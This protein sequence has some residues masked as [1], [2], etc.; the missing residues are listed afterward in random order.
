MKVLFWENELTNL[1]NF[2]IIRIEKFTLLI[3]CATHGMTLSI[4]NHPR[5]KEI[6]SELGE[7]CKKDAVSAAFKLLVEFLANPS[8]TYLNLTNSLF[9]MTD[10]KPEPKEKVVVELV[11]P[12]TIIKP[13]DVVPS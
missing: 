11:Q 4:C 5:V 13:N 2:Q 8:Q 1:D 3:Q 6:I 9:T 7:D 12:A 10:K